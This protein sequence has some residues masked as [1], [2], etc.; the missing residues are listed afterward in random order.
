MRHLLKKKH[1]TQDNDA[2]VPF[3]LGTLGPHVDLCW[4]QLVPFNILR[5][6]ACFRSSRMWITFNKFST[7]FE[8][9]VSHFY[10]H[11]T[12]C[13]IPKRL[14]NHLNSFHR[15][16][17]K[18]NTNLMHID[19]CTCSVILNVMTTQYTC[20]LTGVYHPHWLVQWSRHGSHML[21][22]VHSPWLPGYIDVSQNF[23]VIL[24]IAVLFPDKTHCKLIKML[25]DKLL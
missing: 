7:T 2:S 13:I 14:L 4:L 8:A 19:C 20:S 5:C 6:F 16:M 12:H 10:L 3:K 22:P 15:V 11:R 24:T 18:L 21:I 23:L 17:F 25:C 9:F 1:C